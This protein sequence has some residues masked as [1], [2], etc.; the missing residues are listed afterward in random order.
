[1][2]RLFDDANT[3]YLRIG[4]AVKSTEPVSAA[5]W[6]YPDETVNTK[7]VFWMGDK[8]NAN[9]F[10]ALNL[11]SSGSG[12]NVRAEA[13]NDG[14]DPTGFAESSGTYSVNTWHHVG[15]VWTSDTDRDVYLDGVGANN[16][17]TN[18]GG[19][20]WDRTTFGAEDGSTQSGLMSGRIAEA[21]VWDVSLTAAEMASLAAGF[22]PLLIR[23]KELKFYAPLVRSIYD[24]ILLFSI[25]D[26]NGTTV[27][28]HPPII[29][30]SRP[31]IISRPAA[32]GIDFSAI[33]QLRQSGGMIGAVWQ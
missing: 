11:E 14:E 1:M 23:T 6:V 24:Y 25:T 29:Y 18:N 13:R 8:D 2:S 9:Q 33:D 21:A 28:S 27:A 26:G 16:T 20:G 4:A 17:D 30:P 10:I 31:F 12:N 32:A 5:A 3:D 7:Y 22:S 15:G 19:T